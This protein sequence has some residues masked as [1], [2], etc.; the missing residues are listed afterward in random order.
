MAESPETNHITIQAT[1]PK[2]KIARLLTE[3]GII[4]VAHDEDLANMDR[5]ILSKRAVIERRTGS[6]FIRGIKDKT[7]FSHA[8][9]LREQFE[10]PI[11]ILEGSVNFEYGGFH[12]QAVRGA[13]TALALVYGIT[14]LSS[15]DSDETARLIAMAARHEQAGV[16][17]ISLIPKRKAASLP[18]MQRRVIEMLPGCGMAASKDLLQ[19]FGSIKRITNASAIEFREVRGIGPHKAAEIERVLNAE[20]EAIEAERHLEDAIEA[21]PALL[22]E[23]DVNLVARQH[24]LYSEKGEC[25]IIDM[26]FHDPENNTLYLVELKLGKPGKEHYL[27]IQR[28]LDHVAESTL[29]RAYL[30][31]GAVARGVL[32]T[33]ETCSFNPEDK[34]ITVRVVNTADAIQ[35]LKLLRYD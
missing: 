21:S 2:G 35:V 22:F 13:M 19:H 32:A 30:D 6:T 10:I 12:P 11:I 14:L 26:V 18:D 20:Y 17:E 31:A 16:P 28:Y 8:I 9:D 25:H 3:L 29:L 23:K 4:I 1:K 33:I 34:D 7:L 5:Y 24:H 27:Q 15:P